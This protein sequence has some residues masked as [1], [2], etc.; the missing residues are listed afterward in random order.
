GRARVQRRV[1]GGAI[2]AAALLVAAC[3][4]VHTPLLTYATDDGASPAGVLLDGRIETSPDTPCLLLRPLGYPP[5]ALAWPPG[6][7]ATFD[8]LRIYDPTGAPVADGAAD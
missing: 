8:A 5:V 1:A 6:Y 4:A 2:A 7:S 3:S